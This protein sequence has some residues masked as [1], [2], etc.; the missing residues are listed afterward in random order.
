MLVVKLLMLLWRFSGSSKLVTEPFL[1]AMPSLRA[2]LSS[3]FEHTKDLQL[4]YVAKSLLSAIAH[5]Y[6]VFGFG[7]DR[8][9]IVEEA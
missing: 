6:S 8:L 9:R 7:A 4:T 1:G 5:S 2:R 3:L